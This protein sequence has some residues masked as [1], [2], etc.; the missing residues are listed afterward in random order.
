MPKK[1]MFC[2]SEVF[3][4]HD[5]IWTHQ[6]VSKGL[7]QSQ[8]YSFTPYGGVEILNF[9]YFFALLKTMDQS[10]TTLDRRIGAVGSS[11]ALWLIANRRFDLEFYFQVLE[12]KYVS[13]NSDHHK[14]RS[15]TASNTRA[16]FLSLSKEETLFKYLNSYPPPTPRFYP[17]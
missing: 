10:V 16:V 3:L 6:N 4:T 15:Y 13:T 12:W 8:G 9:D 5:V 1:K 7:A 2:L 17:Q 14:L 11:E